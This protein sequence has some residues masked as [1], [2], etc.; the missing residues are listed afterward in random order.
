MNASK[1]IGWALISGGFAT[2]W[3]GGRALGERERKRNQEGQ[4]QKRKPLLETPTSGIQWVGVGLAWVLVSDGSRPV[5]WARGWARGWAL[6]KDWVGVGV[7]VG[8]GFHWF[9]DLV[10]G[11]AGVGRKKKNSRRKKSRKRLKI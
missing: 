3:V 9:R 7:G 8:V 1:I 11:R 2:G 6:G 5:G 4:D 10:G